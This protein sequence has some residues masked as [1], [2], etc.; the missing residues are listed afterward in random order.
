[1]SSWL[2][3]TKVIFLILLGYV[4]CEFRDYTNSYNHTYSLHDVRILQHYATDHWRMAVGYQEF[5]TVFCPDYKPQFDVG[6]T[7]LLLKYED[8]GTCWSINNH[9]LGYIIL[10]DKQGNIILQKGDKP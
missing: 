7:L 8:K 4:I 5:D 6:M 1:M 2:K 3:I 10:R 9:K